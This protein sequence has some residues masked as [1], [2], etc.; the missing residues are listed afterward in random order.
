MARYKVISEWSADSRFG[1]FTVE[2]ADIRDTKGGREYARGAY[3]VVDENGKAAVRGKG[4]TAPFFGES[5]WCGAERLA[6]DLAFAD[7][8][9]D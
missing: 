9:N 2:T 3:R 1:R 4:G 7:R 5:A 8:F 6:R